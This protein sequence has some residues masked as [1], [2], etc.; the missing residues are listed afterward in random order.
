MSTAREYLSK[1]APF[2]PFVARHYARLAG[3]TGWSAKNL[4]R[5]IHATPILPNGKASDL[6]SQLWKVLSTKHGHVHYEACLMNNTCERVEG[7]QRTTCSDW[8]YRGGRVTC[9]HLEAAFAA[10]S[11]YTAA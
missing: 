5:V 1:D 6:L 2:S 3:Q 10:Q 8:L 11:N 9:A 7:N 4:W